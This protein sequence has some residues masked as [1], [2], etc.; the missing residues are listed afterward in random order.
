MSYTQTAL[1][2]R[3]GIGET[4]D[5]WGLS[6]S[7][8]EV[9]VFRA[10]LLG[11]KLRSPFDVLLFVRIVGERFNAFF[12]M[13]VRGVAVSDVTDNGCSIDIIV[14]SPKSGVS[15]TVPSDASFAQAI[16]GDPD[17]RKIFPSIQVV[18]PLTLE[19]TS[20]KDAIDHWRA[21]PVLWDHALSGSNNRGGPTDAFASPAEYSIVKGRADDGKA[22]TPWKVPK[23]GLDPTPSAGDGTGD[24]TTILLV[25][26]GLGVLYMVGRKRR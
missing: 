26:V 13:D 24:G 15:L 19:L 5:W 3:R 22:A 1:G 10:Q 11:V 8:D 23:P 7:T 2:L 9:F 21:Q 17:V 6:A 12:P 4:S 20:P 25:L 14:T 16:M 18:N